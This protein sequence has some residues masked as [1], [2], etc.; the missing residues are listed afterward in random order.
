MLSGLWIGSARDWSQGGPS[1]VL[2]LVLPSDL[3][4]LAVLG[5]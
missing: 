4:V 1:L 2:A 3:L 5:F